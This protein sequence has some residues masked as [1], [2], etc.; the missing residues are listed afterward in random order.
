M[1]TTQNPKSLP[2]LAFPKVQRREEGR[3]GEDRDQKA[4][5]R[6]RDAGEMWRLRVKETKDNWKP[7]TAR[8]EEWIEGGRM[9]V[10]GERGR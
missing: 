7:E 9:K 3:R 5:R 6:W 1:L 4:R 2:G 10:V 8:A